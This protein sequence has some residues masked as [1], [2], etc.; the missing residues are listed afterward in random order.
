MNQQ[1]YV[2]QCLEAIG[3]LD[4]H[5]DALEVI[6]RFKQSGLSNEQVAT[7][8]INDPLGAEYI[9]IKGGTFIYSEGKQH[10]TMPDCYFAKYMVTNQQYRRF[11]SYLEKNELDFAERV[12]VAKYKE[13]LDGMA[14]GIKGFT[15]YLK[16]EQSFAERF[17]SMYDED[18]KFSGDEQPVIGVSWFAARAYCMWLSLL[19]SNGEKADSYRLPTD[20]EW[21]WAAG[22]QRDKPDEVLE[23]QEYPWGVGIS[24]QHANYNSNEGQT[25]P[26]GRYP[27]GATQEGLYDMA[28]NVL[29]WIENWYNENTRS[30]RVLRGGSWNYYAESV[31]SG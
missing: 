4:G 12:S 16:E 25:T 21:E 17:R 13:H 1:R 31:V 29:E 19:T 14:K 15:D 9:L 3:K 6:Q 22:G 23:V 11:I 28:G 18:R 20:V 30:F 10:K 7:N 24:S 8:V 2:V 27:K 26:V 5:T